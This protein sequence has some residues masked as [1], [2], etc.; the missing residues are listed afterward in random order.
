MGSMSAGQTAPC[1][2]A[3]SPCPQRVRTATA[4]IPRCL[5]LVVSL[6]TRQ[7]EASKDEVLTK[8]IV[9]KLQV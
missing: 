3:A 9:F 7:A 1:S 8:E 4:R 5:W 2:H 6:C